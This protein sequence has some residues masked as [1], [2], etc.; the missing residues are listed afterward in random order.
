MPGWAGC[1][2]KLATSV[3]SCLNDPSNTTAPAAA[4]DG[5]ADAG[6]TALL[7][8]RAAA[9]LRNAG[10][11]TA[12]GATL[13]QDTP[14]LSLDGGQLRVTVT[15]TQEE[16]AQLVAASRELVNVVRLSLRLAVGQGRSQSV[17]PL[18]LRPTA[19]E[20]QLVRV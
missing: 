6:T 13:E 1:A 2:C 16:P 8:K 9:P 12:Q 3:P 14:I 11:I 17:V 20:G 5:P 10:P 7:L 18:V 4:V 19:A 15:S